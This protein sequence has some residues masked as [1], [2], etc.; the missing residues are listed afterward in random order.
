MSVELSQLKYFYFVAKSGGFSKAARASRIQ[1]S[2]L[3]KY[4]R[5]IE[6]QL[7]VELLNRERSHVT[8]TNAG[9]RLFESCSVIFDELE[10]IP[11]AV[12]TAKQK[13][14]GSIN[15][16]ASS[17]IGTYLV[18]AVH[19]VFL[20]AYPNVWPMSYSAPA[21]LLLEKTLDSTLDFSLLL[22]NGSL[23][24]E[25]ESTPLASVPHSVVISATHL[26]SP[27]IR[28]SFIGSREVDSIRAKDFAT[29][30]RIQKLEPKTKI[31]MSSN[32][33]ACHKEMVLRGLGIAILPLFAISNELKKG[34][35]R[36]LYPKEDF[37]FPIQVV[38]RK[39]KMLSAQAQVFL[40]TM[41]NHLSMKE[42]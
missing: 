29:L 42:T 4:V 17:A 40:E 13:I 35:L 11:Q 1:Q 26:K 41:R 24:K 28:R 18:P 21:D 38:K 32:D 6:E 16:G 5:L 36:K 19:E 34:T 25:L 2:S 10:R 37:H 20:A 8:L 31:R 7:G 27:E 3:S 30:R 39:T 23:P 33:L 15:F 14:E 22:Y 12:T 9:R